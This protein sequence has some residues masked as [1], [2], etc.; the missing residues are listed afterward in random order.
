MLPIIPPT[1][2]YNSSTTTLRKKVAELTR[3][4]LKFDRF[5]LLSRTVPHAHT[6]QDPAS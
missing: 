2:E 3:F 4:Y 6:N 1:D 5:Y